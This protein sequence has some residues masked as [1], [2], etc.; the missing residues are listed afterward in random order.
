MK[1]GML[2][3]CEVTQRVTASSRLEPSDLSDM[4]Y[5]GRGKKWS[6]YVAQSGLELLASRDPLV[7][8]S[9]VAGVTGLHHHA[10]L[11]CGYA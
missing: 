11:N 3:V 4:L 6:R 9:Q 2:N 8:A 7:L 5:C 10:T 1:A